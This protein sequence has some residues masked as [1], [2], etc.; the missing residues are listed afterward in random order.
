MN[1]YKELFRK[2]QAIRSLFL[3]EVAFTHDE[4]GG[5]IMDD[6]QIWA[7]V[8]RLSAHFN[9]DAKVFLQL[10]AQVLEAAAADAGFGKLR[11]IAGDFGKITGQITISIRG[12]FPAVPR[13]NIPPDQTERIMNRR[14]GVDV[15]LSN[16][17]LFLTPCVGWLDLGQSERTETTFPIGHDPDKYLRELSDGL[18]ELT[19]LDVAA[20]LLSL[21]KS[22][23]ERV[24]N[25]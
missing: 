1:I 3:F 23:V 13:K 2:A 25:S 18:D 4:W 6:G 20:G 9:G 24:V 11:V 16:E 17:K 7:D 14:S 15:T 10:T 8:D 22:K 21:V 12:D 19:R 5:I